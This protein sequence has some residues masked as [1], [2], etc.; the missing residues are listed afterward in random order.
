MLIWIVGRGGLLGSAVAR[1]MEMRPDISEYLALPLPWNDRE[2]LEM[3]FQASAADFARAAAHQP[4]AIVW[5]AGH[6]SVSTP[7][8][9]AFAE[10][11]A[12][13]LLVSAVT[14]HRPSGVGRFFLSSS[15]GGV[16]AGSHHPPFTLNT[17]VAPLSV[18]GE[19]KLAQESLVR[20][21]L[22]GVCEVDIGRLSNLYGPGQ[23]LVKLQGLI[24][25]LIK[26]VITRTPINVFVSLDTLRDYLFVDDAADAILDI[27]LRPSSPLHAAWAMHLLASGQPV[28]LG[29]LINLVQDISRARVP[30]ALGVHAS[31]AG[32]S[33]DLR[34]IPAPLATYATTSLPQGVKLV[35]LDL[36][37]R[38]QANS[39]A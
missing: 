1:R 16:F 6:A 21:R 3:A 5:A 17:S 8:A 24:S 7:H 34:I 25:A 2:G 36:L 38:L 39:L 35:Y 15:A 19:L 23:D 12:L 29:H 37:Q 14:V 10:L 9:E 28:S 31:A 11:E 4:W 22:D 33:R 32:Q 30:L 26:A 18:Y 13:D 27:C 20:T